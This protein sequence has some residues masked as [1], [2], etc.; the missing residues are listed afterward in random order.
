[1]NR[2]ISD[3]PDQ[4]ASGPICGKTL[5][6]RLP[7]LKQLFTLCIQPRPALGFAANAAT[8]GL[9]RQTGAKTFLGLAKFPVKRVGSQRLKH[10]IRHIRAGFHQSVSGQQSQS[11]AR[12]VY[13]S[14]PI[15]NY[16]ASSSRFSSSLRFVDCLRVQR[17]VSQKVFLEIR[18]TV[19][20]PANQCPQTSRGRCS[21]PVSYT[22]LLKKGK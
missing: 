4:F 16:C 17:Q 9:G 10:A 12:P 2:G 14:A 6:L 15:R 21:A 8:P 18:R 19:L 1:M 5:I 20:V 3:L 11:G 13:P 7:F 22:H